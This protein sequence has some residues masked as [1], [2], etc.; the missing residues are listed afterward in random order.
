MNIYGV[1]PNPQMA[2]TLRRWA[3]RQASNA[4]R[5]EVKR[6]RMLQ[7]E[8]EH[9]MR[10]LDALRILDRGFLSESDPIHRTVYQF[11]PYIPTLIKLNQKAPRKLY[12]FNE[13]TQDPNSFFEN[14]TIK[15]ISH[16]ISTKT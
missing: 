3:E 14:Q 1:N 6:N 16:P 8:R 15:L 4:A 9:L 12:P 7:D 2:V 13:S 10:A 5:W 11:R